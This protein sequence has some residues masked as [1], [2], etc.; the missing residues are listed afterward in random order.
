M[1][2]I[3]EEFKSTKS[4]SDLANT[5]KTT[6]SGMYGFG[7]KFGNLLGGG[8]GLEFFTPHDEVFGAADSNPPTFSVGT[9]VPATTVMF[10]GKSSAAVH[11]YVWDLG[12]ERLVRLYGPYRT[13]EKGATAKVVQGMLSAMR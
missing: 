12:S 8:N 1:K 6:A 13:G 11:M 3:T 5:F 7:K 2:A 4:V 10:G 9:S